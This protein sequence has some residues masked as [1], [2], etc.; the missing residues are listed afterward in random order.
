[1]AQALMGLKLAV[2]KAMVANKGK[3]P[4]TEIMAASLRGS[5]WVS[6]AGTI[7]MALSNGQQAIQD[8]A[9]GRTNW[10]EENQMVLLEDIQ[11]FAATCVNPPLNIKSEDWLKSGFAGAKCDSMSGTDKKSKK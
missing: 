11:R 9:I 4:S 10:S 3:K 1:M 7:R 2:E 5:E 6:P 8:T